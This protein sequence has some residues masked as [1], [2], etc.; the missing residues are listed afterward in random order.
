M[1]PYPLRVINV[2]NCRPVNVVFDKRPITTAEILQ[3]FS[4]EKTS[5]WEFVILG[6]Y[7]VITLLVM[8]NITIIVMIFTA[9]MIITIIIAG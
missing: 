9:I 4:L 6:L 8:T 5:W 2:K 3:T 1:K 7:F